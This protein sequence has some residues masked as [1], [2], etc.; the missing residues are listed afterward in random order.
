[1][2]TPEAAG[3]GHGQH[4][5]VVDAGGLEL[6]ELGAQALAVAH[7]VLGAQVG[8]VPEV[9][10]GEAV[11][12]AVEHEAGALHLYEAGVV[13]RGGWQARQREQSQQQRAQGDRRAARDVVPLHVPAPPWPWWSGCTGPRGRPRPASGNDTTGRARARGPASAA[14]TS[15]FRRWRDAP[16]RG[17]A[18]VA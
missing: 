15:A 6:V 14:P 17:E 1:D 8:A 11:G 10:A 5:Q 12:L 7:A 18:W 9:G 13:R 16:D 4:A 3:L 2:A